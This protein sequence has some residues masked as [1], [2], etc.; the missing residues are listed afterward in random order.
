MKY[1]G[2]WVRWVAALIDSIVL[3]LSIM[4]V[5]V[6][7]AF[8]APP[9]TFESPIWNLLGLVLGIGYYAGMESSSKRGTIGKMAM[10]LKVCTTEGEQLTFL[11]AFGRYF[12]RFL[13]VIT[14][15]IGYIM[16]AFTKKKQT[17]HDMVCD[18][19]VLASG[20]PLGDQAE[21]T[22]TPPAVEAPTAP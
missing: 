5:I 19:V 6:P 4:V 17:L 11:R 2:F 7:I 12:A 10:G 13:S 20:S 9:E 22:G 21:H 18:T 3:M 1:A 14:L 15:F 16:G 8:T